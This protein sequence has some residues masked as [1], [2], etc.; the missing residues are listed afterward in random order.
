[1]A[2]LCKNEQLIGEIMNDVRTLSTSNG[3][4]SFE[5]VCAV[6]LESEPFSVENGL[7]T[8]T[9]KLKRQQMAQNFKRQCYIYIPISRSWPES[10][11]KVKLTISVDLIYCQNVVS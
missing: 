10:W 2:N 9:F 8:P 4:T 6:Y 7:M 11:E 1:M 3:L 5:T